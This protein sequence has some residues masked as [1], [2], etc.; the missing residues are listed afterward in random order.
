MRTASQ[1][2]LANSGPASAAGEA[3][4]P[5]LNDQ[6][7]NIIPPITDPMGRYWQQP[8]RDRL[9]ID[10]THAVCSLEDFSVL[11]EYSST[12]PSGKYSGKMWKARRD[13][14]LASGRDGWLLCWYAPH[15][16]AAELTINSRILLVDRLPE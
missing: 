9:L 14:G 15:P 10:D 16:Y 4:N 12:I 7:D 11:M 5:L 3:N 2:P 6:F 13:L 1:Q 8:R